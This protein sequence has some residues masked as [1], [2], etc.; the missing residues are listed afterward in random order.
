MRT[1]PSTIESA[2]LAC[3]LAAASSCGGAGT[4]RGEYCGTLVFAAPGRI[5]I[6]LPPVSTQSLARDVYAQVL[7]RL[8]DIGPSL[9]TLGD[10]EFQPQLARSWTW[11]TPTTLVFHLDPRARWQDG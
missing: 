2:L 8:A 11:K 4:C 10:K 5:D 7:L 1:L 3:L 9:N 6:L